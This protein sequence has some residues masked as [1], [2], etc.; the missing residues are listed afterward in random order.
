M[1]L[2]SG[3]ELAFERGD[4]DVLGV[5]FGFEL[6]PDVSGAGV[7]AQDPA[8]HAVAERLQPDLEAHFTFPGRK[9]IDTAPDFADRDRAQIKIFFVFF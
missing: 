8:L 6:A 1:A 4:D 2:R 7:K 9:T 3:G 5:P